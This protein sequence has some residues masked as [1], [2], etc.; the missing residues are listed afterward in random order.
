MLRF[1]SDAPWEIIRT[2]TSSSAAEHVTSYARR[3]ADVIAYDADD[4]LIFFGATS[5]NCRAR[6]ISL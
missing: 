4:G 3:L 2:L 6:D 1:S 5:A